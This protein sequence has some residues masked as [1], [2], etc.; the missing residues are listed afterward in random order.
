MYLHILW[1][2]VLHMYMYVL[3]SGL[4]MQLVEV[5]DGCSH[6]VFEHS[7]DYQKVQFDFWDAVETYDPNSIAV[8][9]FST[10]TNPSV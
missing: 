5:K 4:S 8:S 7:G 10:S 2:L 3:C 6:F 1:E 9:W